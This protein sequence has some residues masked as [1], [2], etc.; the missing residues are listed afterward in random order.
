MNTIDGP[1]F[2]VESDKAMII[3]GNSERDE[4]GDFLARTLDERGIFEDIDVYTLNHSAALLGRAAI[5]KAMETR[6]VI[7]HSAGIMRVPKALQIVAINPPEPVP[8]GQLVKRAMDVA[9]DPIVP[10]VGAHQTGFMDMLKAGLE[11]ARSP[12][13]TAK[14][15]LQIAGGYSST[16]RLT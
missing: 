6:T 14:T 2:Q 10:E 16:E 4:V 8:L 13:V 7:T 3:L 12:I 15:S 11:M 1:L 5:Q 9:N